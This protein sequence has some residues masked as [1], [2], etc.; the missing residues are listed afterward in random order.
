VLILLLVDGFEPF[1]AWITVFY[2][3]EDHR[4]PPL[5]RVFIYAGHL[6][7]DSSTVCPV[8]HRPFYVLVAAPPLVVLEAAADLSTHRF[9]AK[10]WRISLETV[11]L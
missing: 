9:L 3:V 2:R 4:P 11:A 8:P 6:V 7:P 1:V 10:S 5:L